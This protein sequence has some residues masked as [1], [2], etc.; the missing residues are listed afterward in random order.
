MDK[1]TLLAVVLSVVIIVGG[2]VLQPLLFPPKPQPAPTTTQQAP[3]AQ[4]PAAPTTSQQAPASNAQ[5]TTPA[6]GATTTTAVAPG[7]VVPTLES[8]PPA[9]QPGAFV[10]DTNVFSLTFTSDGGTLAS[11]KLKKYHNVDG[12]PVEML[13]M[14][15]TEAA[16]D[17]PFALSFGDYKAEQI[18]VPFA[19][20]ESVNGTE[21][22]YDFTRAFLSPTGV[23]FTLH[24][25]YVFQ[26]D[27]YLFK[28]FVT[29]ENSVNDFPALD[30]GGYSYTLTLGP[31]IGPHYAKLDGRADFR[32]YAFYADGKRQDPKVGM[33]QLKELDRHMTWTGIVGKYFTGLVQPDANVTKTVYDSRKL[34][35]GY[36]RSQI[37]LE[38][39]TL[40]SAKISD[41]Y[42]FYLGPM[43]KDILGRYNDA[44]NNQFA[45]SGL[46][47]D[48]VIT[49]SIL[50]GW[51]ATLFQYCL[52]FF[53]LL[54]PNYGVAII[55]LTL[56]TK[57]VFF[58]LTFKSS[59]S[60]AKMA[61]LNPKMQEIRTRLKD[62]PDKMNQEIAQLYQKEK[63]NPMSGCLPLL[64]QIPVFFALYNL[65]NSQFELRG[66]HFIAGWIP[67]LS[68]PESVL[69]FG[70]TIPLL[71]WTA[72]RVLPIIMVATQILSSKITQPP[73]TQ[74]QGGMQTALMM[75]LMPIVFFFILYDMPSGLVLYW[76]VQNVL[77]M[78]QQL[79]INHR[80]MRLD[81]AK[82][83]AGPVFV[84]GGSGHG[85]KIARKPGK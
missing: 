4:Q 45:I 70:F 59:E 39:V 6:H 52:D 7:V 22:T 2:M 64:L 23:P 77:S 57:I 79:Y 31:Q 14:P 80:R 19:L 29:I 74:A 10:R 26:R 46:H 47:A 35:E 44:G 24:K 11:V 73:S 12:S 15:K 82:A 63:I 54:I 1:K 18:N 40:K 58:P 21:S 62:K 61:E 84:K 27:E 83:A 16:G 71:G 50:L 25:T 85:S 69:D 8:A 34:I 81:A 38:R 60:M 55:L 36:D 30:F 56:L 53:Y 37:S 49:S 42:R 66:A 20:N 33:G 9:S 28:I 65:L 72:L 68:A 17:L 67:D 13:L 32:N 76:T 3:A 43:K 5:A 51:L 75:Y 78:V 41:E 48:Q